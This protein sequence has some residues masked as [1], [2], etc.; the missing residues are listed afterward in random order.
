MTERQHSGQPP[1]KRCVRGFTLIE[2]LVVIA[3]IAIL[4]AM[5]L[6]A[7]AKAKER[8]KRTQCLSNLKQLGLAST[9]YAGDYNDLF[10]VCSFN[11]GWNAQ[12]PYQM[13]NN[14]LSTASQLG[15]NVNDPGFAKVGYSTSATIWTCPNRPSLPAPNV[16]PNPQT[17]SMGY[18]YYGGL[19]NWTFNGNKYASASAIKVANSRPGWVLASDLML[20]M[21]TGQWTD[22]GAT[23]PNQ[24]TYGLP[25]H[26]NGAL[27]AGGN[28]VYADGSVF[29]AKAQDTYN[30]YSPQ[31]NRNFY[32]AQ[33]DLGKFPIPVG[34]IPKFPN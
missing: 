10:E 16:W 14:L 6:P 25:A 22:P 26:K 9:M 17:W 5:L 8:A 34:N 19:S 24:G 11:S 28:Q 3:I 27:P 29:W 18:A 7:L 32:W 4:A 21:G 2:L 15:F 30:F 1:V 20:R 23:T 12:N 31:A 13:D 33:T